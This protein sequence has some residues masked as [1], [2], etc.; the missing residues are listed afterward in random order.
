MGQRR[1]GE[2]C[3]HSS[4]VLAALEPGA[5]PPSRIRNFS[6]IAH[7]DHGKSTLADRLLEVTGTVTGK[8]MQA[9]VLDNMDIERERGITIKLNTARMNCKDENGEDYILNLID[10]PG[11]VDFTY[12]VSRSLAACEG[13]LLV[14]DASQGVEAQTIANVTLA[15]ENDLEIIPVLNKVDLPAADPDRVAEEIEQVIGIDCTAA[16]RCSAKSGLGVPEIVQA[17]IDQVPPPQATAEAPL[18]CL[19]YDSQYDM[20][21]GAIVMFRVVDG[22][23]S[24]GQKIRFMAT[25]KEFDIVEIGYMV[26]GKRVPVKKLCAGEVGYFCAAIKQVADA[27]VG[28]TVCQAGM[29]SKVE[30][31]PGYTPAVPMVFCGLFPADSGGFES[32]KQAFERLALSDASLAYEVENSQ[33][34]GLGFRCG[35]LGILHM[36]VIKERIEREHGVML[37]VTA[38]SVRYQIYCKDGRELEIQFANQLPPPAEV[39]EIREPY[40]L[41]EMIVPEE[42]IGTCMELATQRRCLY[43]STDFLTL[44]RVLLKYEM[45]MA[46]MIRDF[47]SELKSRSRGYASMDYQ[48]LDFR[49]DDLVKLEIDVNKTTAPPLAQ[50][51]HRS[52]A[53]DLGRRMAKILKE[54]IPAQQIKVII[55]ARVGSMI[56]AAESVKAVRKDVL[57]KCYGG[58]VTRKMKLLRKQAEGKKRMQAIGRVNIP[59]DAI[60]SVIRQT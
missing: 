3:Q 58:D 32:L 18:R 7:I 33:A 39:R 34:L 29:Q 49:P 57:Q 52:R 47:F 50:I 56:V 40:V 21:Q 42:H 51:V 25:A 24:K 60:I 44:G 30:Q 45:P 14:V 28:D 36:E 46:E 2:R 6:I 13:A 12:E 48:M 5:S 9:Q 53:V 15:M 10:T 38:P 31:L 17:I 35:F 59:S 22:V 11:H 16:L 43:K 1:R 8:E 27:S 37:T 23:I 55:Q 4:I 41:L 54:E 20:Y 19:V 26:G